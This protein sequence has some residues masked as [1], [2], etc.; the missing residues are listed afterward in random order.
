[1]D[2]EAL[3]KICRQIGSP[4]YVF[5]LDAVRER[6]ELIRSRLDHKTEFCYAMKANPF[7]ALFMSTVADRLEVCSPG[8]YEICLAEGID[9]GMIVVS[10]VNKTKESME[11][12]VTAAAG[13]GVYTIESMQHYEILESCARKHGFALQVDIRLSS[14]NQFG[15]DRTVWKQ[16]ARN[17]MSSDVLTLRG[18]HYYS[19]TQKK[20]SKIAKELKALSD[21]AEELR[22]ELGIEGLELE[23]GPGLQVSYFEGEEEIS[24]MDQL[25]ALKELLRD[26]VG[27][28]GVVLEM[29]RFLA[30]MCG[31]YITGVVDVKCTEGEYFA[32][33]DGGIHQINYFGQ[34]MGMK[35]P[36]I[37][38]T[39]TNGREL[40]GESVKYN[41]CGS[42]CTT[43]DV[44][45]RQIELPR[46]S[47][48][49]RLIFARCGAYS[50][51]EGMTLFLSRELPQVYLC[52]KQ[53][54]EL[55]R[56]MMRTDI[57]NSKMKGE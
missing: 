39:D 50:V 54:L 9:P 28:R 51:T 53:Q 47:V 11:R 57:W 17:V 43:N 30:S 25:D 42:L 45:T 49:D 36:F 29:G 8:E 24:P 13:R 23:Y 14:G 52:E 18:L 32:I 4:S 40:A 10:G 12:I 16:I 34:M 7:I 31:Y 20:I 56:P 35:H 44:L 27:F 5:D 22:E 41:L 38:T 46:L 21:F 2:R 3:R 15:V 55:V 48:G 26:L 37:D 1:M 19:G 33:L 6:T